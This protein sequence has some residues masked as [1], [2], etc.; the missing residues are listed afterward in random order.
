MID[1]TCASRRSVMSSAVAGMAFAVGRRPARAAVAEGVKTWRLYAECRWGQVHMRAAAPADGPGK[2]PIAL[3]HTSPLSGLEYSTLLAELGKDRLVLAPDNP[4][5]GGSDRPPAPP[6]IP[7]YA[8][9]LAEAIANTGLIPNDAPYDIMGNHTGTTMCVEL[10]TAHAAKIHRVV[11]SG[12]PL[13]PEDLRRERVARYGDSTPIF[14]NPDYLPNNF[15]NSVLKDGPTP[16]ERR[17]ELFL[18]GPRAG[19]ASWWAP[20]AALSYPLRQKLAD[21]RQPTL[22]LI[23]KDRL[24]DNTRES[25]T[26]APNATVVDIENETGEP[27]WDLQPG[28]VAKKIRDFVDA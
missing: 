16:R 6:D 15:R 12:T 7:A 22:F 18:E 26:L 5:F 10:A 23:T 11:L 13:Y 2:R 28:L 9:T 4:G 20:K 8:A 19:S 14:D 17:L 27:A 24:A 25:A 3:F 21:V 1:R